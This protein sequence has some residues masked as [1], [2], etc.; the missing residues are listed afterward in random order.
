MAR[1]KTHLKAEGAEFL[2]LGQLLLHRIPSYKTYTNMPGYD[3]VA[4]H[5]ENNTSARIQVKADGGQGP[6]AFLS[7]VLIVIL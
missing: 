5:P 4:T 7:I 6:A 1:L 3:L 2:V